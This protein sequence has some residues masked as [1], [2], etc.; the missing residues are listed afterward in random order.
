M[1]KELKIIGTWNSNFRPDDKELCD[2]NKSI[3]I[4]LNKEINLQELISHKST[5]ENSSSLIEKIN[6][7]ER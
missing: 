2:W 7:R 5:L 4:L 6:L 3:E 1:R